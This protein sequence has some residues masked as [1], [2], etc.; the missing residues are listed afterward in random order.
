M[1]INARRTTVRRI[2]TRT[3]T[4]LKKVEAEKPEREKNPLDENPD[5][6]IVKS[7]S[8][9]NPSVGTSSVYYSYIDNKFLK[10]HDEENYLEIFN[11]DEGLLKN[12]DNVNSAQDEYHEAKKKYKEKV[13]SEGGEIK[14][15]PGDSVRSLRNKLTYCIRAS[16][17]V[18]KK[19]VSKEGKSLFNLLVQTSKLERDDQKGIFHQWDMFDSYMSRFIKKKAED[20]RQEEIKMRGWAKERKKVEQLGESINRPSLFKALKLL[21]R[22]VMQIVNQGKYFFYREWNGQEGQT[23]AANMLAMLLSFPQNARIKNRSVTAL[24]WNTK[25]E[26]LFAARYGNYE[27]PK[28]KDEK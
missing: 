11:L 21:E 18:N 17:T 27:F 8:F 20:K 16:E 2:S 12:N 1:A 4:N 6:Y 10:V 15:D 13:L 5:A 23:D 25:F 7:L 14:E 28:R 9:V 22:Q 19:I 24:C 3:N 26:D